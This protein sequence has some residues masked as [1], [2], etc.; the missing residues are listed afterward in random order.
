MS[1]K[2]PDF[3]HV[4]PNAFVDLAELGGVSPKRSRIGVRNDESRDFSGRDPKLSGK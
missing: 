4:I 1:R 2:I 3:R